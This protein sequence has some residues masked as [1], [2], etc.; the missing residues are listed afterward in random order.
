MIFWC[1]FV[2]VFADLGCGGLA[3][4][5]FLGMLRGCCFVLGDSRVGAALV[6]AVVMGIALAA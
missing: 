1:F 6:E 5:C 2:A 3:R 4:F